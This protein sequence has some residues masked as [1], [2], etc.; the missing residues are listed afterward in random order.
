MDYRFR[1]SILRGN[2]S[3]W[4]EDCKGQE[5]VMLKLKDL[6]DKYPHLIISKQRV[7]KEE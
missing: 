6:I 5:D 7:N 2:G 3:V 4:V 1:I